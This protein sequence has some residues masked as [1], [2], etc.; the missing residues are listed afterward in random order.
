MNTNYSDITLEINGILSAPY[1]DG[2]ILKNRYR[3][4]SQDSGGQIGRAHV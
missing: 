3:I 2:D 4:L 1:K